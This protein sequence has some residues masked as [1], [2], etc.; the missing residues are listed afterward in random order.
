MANAVLLFLAADEESERAQEGRAG[1]MEFARPCGGVEESSRW[2]GRYFF[3]L[4]AMIWSLIL[5]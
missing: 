1:C 5:L 3:G 2:S 4:L